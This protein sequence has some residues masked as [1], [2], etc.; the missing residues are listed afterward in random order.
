MGKLMYDGAHQRTPKRP[1][2]LR[3]YHAEDHLVVTCNVYKLNPDGTKGEF[4]RTEEHRPSDVSHEVIRTF[5]NKYV[6]P[7]RK[8]SP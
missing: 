5:R 6:T 1:L 4:L 3:E 7:L 2:D 8:K